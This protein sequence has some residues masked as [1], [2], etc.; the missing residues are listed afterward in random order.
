MPLNIASEH[1]CAIRCSIPE[2]QINIYIDKYRV[3]IGVSAII[4]GRDG[5][6]V[7]TVSILNRLRI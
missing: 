6:I 5:D 2:V 4:V 1:N 3:A 7:V